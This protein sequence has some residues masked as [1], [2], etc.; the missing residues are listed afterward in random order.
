MAI[1]CLII[2]DDKSVVN[3]IE[4]VRPIKPDSTLTNTNFKTT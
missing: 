2:E 1:K 4:T 3:I